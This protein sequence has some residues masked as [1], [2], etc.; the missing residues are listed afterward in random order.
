VTRWRNTSSAC[1]LEEIAARHEGVERV[2]AMRA[3]A[4]RVIVDPGKIDDERVP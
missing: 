3:A 4:N 1:G 2:Y